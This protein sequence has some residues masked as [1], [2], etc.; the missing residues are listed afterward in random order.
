MGAP[1][2][3]LLSMEFSSSLASAPQLDSQTKE[4]IGLPPKPYFPEFRSRDYILRRPS[5]KGFAPR[6]LQLVTGRVRQRRDSP[7][8]VKIIPLCTSEELDS[9]NKNSSFIHQEDAQRFATGRGVQCP[10]P[11]GGA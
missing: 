3:P 9:P 2:S 7:L 1:V 8:E 4:L 11:D 6:I 5:G 10:V